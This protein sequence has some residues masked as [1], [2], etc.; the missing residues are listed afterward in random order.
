MQ[1]FGRCTYAFKS[2]LTKHGFE[3]KNTVNGLEGACLW[4]GSLD[5]A[6]ELEEIITEYGFPLDKYDAAILASDEDEDEDE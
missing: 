4:L 6:E 1:A 3:F 5:E 2:I